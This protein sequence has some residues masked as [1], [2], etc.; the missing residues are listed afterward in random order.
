DVYKRQEIRYQA[1]K[2]FLEFDL[3]PFPQTRPTEQPKYYEKKKSV[4]SSEIKTDLEDKRAAEYISPDPK[5]QEQ[6]HSGHGNTS[7]DAA[8][9]E[10]ASVISE[11]SLPVSEPNIQPGSPSETVSAGIGSESPA[12]LSD[13]TNSETEPLLQKEE[14]LDMVD[15]IDEAVENIVIPEGPKSEENLKDSQCLDTA[16]TTPVSLQ[17]LKT[18]EEENKDISAHID[19]AFE[20]VI[21]AED[22][23][24][25]ADQVVLENVLPEFPSVSEEVKTNEVLPDT[26]VSVPVEPVKEVQEGISVPEGGETLPKSVLNEAETSSIPSVNVEELLITPEPVQIPTQSNPAEPAINIDEIIMNMPAEETKEP[27]SK[28]S[29]INPLQIDFLSGLG[30]TTPQ[31]EVF[32]DKKEAA[33]SQPTIS[34][35]E[36]LPADFIVPESPSPRQVSDRVLIDSPVKAAVH[37]VDGDARRGIIRELRESYSEVELFDDETFGHSTKIPVSDIKAVFIMKQAGEKSI[38]INGQRLNV[39]FRDERSISG[40]APEYS[41][42][43]AVF[44]LYPYESAQSARMIIVYRGFVDQVEKL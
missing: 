12:P 38:E 37:M 23:G 35:E 8:A 11:T 17:N 6:N 34:I 31:P 15:A 20:N 40:I 9:Q 33:E 7:T 28:N 1:L 26:I 22:P 29:E 4:S 30:M 3:F 19:S 36:I 44:I 32:S 10:L 39:R 5:A 42:E 25:T 41:D 43:A 24:K 27:V 14:V 2:F 16:E 18:T 21:Q 13:I